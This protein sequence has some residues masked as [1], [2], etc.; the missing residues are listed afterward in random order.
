[1]KKYVDTEFFYRKNRSLSILFIVLLLTELKEE[2][3]HEKL[4]KCVLIQLL[5]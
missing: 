5:F 4:P 1:M 3:A 2:L